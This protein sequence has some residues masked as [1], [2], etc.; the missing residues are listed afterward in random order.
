M[1]MVD[2]VKRFQGIRDQEHVSIILMEWHMD[3]SGQTI[4]DN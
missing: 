4:G 1:A 2:F 3:S